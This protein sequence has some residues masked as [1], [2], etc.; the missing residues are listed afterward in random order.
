MGGVELHGGEH[1]S[2]RVGHAFVE[3]C[4]KWLAGVFP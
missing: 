4:E 2:V 1:G 3:V